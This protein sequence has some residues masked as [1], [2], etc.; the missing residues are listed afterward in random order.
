[1]IVGINGINIR[2]E[3]K[4]ILSSLIALLKEKKFKVYLSEELS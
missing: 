2:G 4:K 3:K 1:M